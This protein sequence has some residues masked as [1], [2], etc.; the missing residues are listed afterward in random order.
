M[1]HGEPG[2]ERLMPELPGPR[3]QHPVVTE[4]DHWPSQQG[5]RPQPA[6]RRRQVRSKPDPTSGGDR[7]Y[8]QPGVP[9]DVAGHP[10]LHPNRLTHLVQFDRE[11]DRVRE[12]RPH[13]ARPHLAFGERPGIEA[14]QPRPPLLVHI[15]T[16]RSRPEHIWADVEVVPAVRADPHFAGGYVRPGARQVSGRASRTRRVL[17][18]PGTERARHP[19][20]SATCPRPPRRCPDRRG[21]SPRPGRAVRHWAGGRPCAGHGRTE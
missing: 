21:G 17:S 13:A 16:G 15:G 11:T 8:V 1:G 9:L 19:I 18:R 2:S 4:P 6:T 7:V 5:S 14:S 20:P 10:R 12:R 3:I